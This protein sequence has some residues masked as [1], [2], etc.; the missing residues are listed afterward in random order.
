[1]KKML[2]AVSLLLIA[3][4]VFAA[5]IFAVPVLPFDDIVDCP[6]AAEAINSLRSK[7]IMIGVAEN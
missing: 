5:G 4:M 7:G 6:W 2:T 1:M 3:A